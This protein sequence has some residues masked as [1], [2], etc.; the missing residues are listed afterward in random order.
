MGGG[1]GALSGGQSESVEVLGAGLG[2]RVQ[3]GWAES[4]AEDWGEGTG[5]LAEERFLGSPSFSMGASPVFWMGW[6]FFANKLGFWLGFSLFFP[7]LMLGVSSG[8]VVE[9]S[10]WGGEEMR[11]VRE[12]F[13]R[14]DL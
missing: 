14:F 4:P 1:K 12:G 5:S 11:S 10:S 2:G 9:G 6:S 7:S 8:V 13:S 3:V